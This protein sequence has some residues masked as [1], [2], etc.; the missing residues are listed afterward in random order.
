MES[1]WIFLI[2]ILLMFLVPFLFKIKKFEHAEVLS[3]ELTR[4]GIFIRYTFLIRVESS[5]ITI[6]VSREVFEHVNECSIVTL[7][8]NTGDEK[9]TSYSV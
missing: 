4:E 9:V 5:K 8:Y 7:Y 2:P 3:K 6:P 1:N